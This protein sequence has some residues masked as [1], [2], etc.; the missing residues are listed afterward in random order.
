MAQSRELGL[1]HA[2]PEPLPASS[3]SRDC[4]HNELPIPDSPALRTALDSS[5]SCCQLFGPIMCCGCDGR[6]SLHSSPPEGSGK[7]QNWEA[8][9]RWHRRQAAA[10]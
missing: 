10:G 3:L 2:S 9:Y 4:V 1:S 6:D 7:L 5:M 8:E